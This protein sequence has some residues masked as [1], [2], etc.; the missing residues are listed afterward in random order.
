MEMRLT[1]SVREGGTLIHADGRLSR[2]GV[3]ELESVLETTS[4]PLTLDLTNLLSAD[5][6]GVAALRSYAGRGVR[7][8]G[9]SP[10]MALLL[11]PEPSRDTR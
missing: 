8:V 9:V 5:D 4:G 1:V 3:P 2:Q 10:Y 7:L 11:K 6:A